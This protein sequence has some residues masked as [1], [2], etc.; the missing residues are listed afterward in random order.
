MRLFYLSLCLLLVSC[1]L[2]NEKL[3]ILKE[4]SEIEKFG[5]DYFINEVN[6][7]QFTDSLYYIVDSKINSLFVLDEDFNFITSVGSMGKGPG[8]FL[9][10]GTVSITSNK[11]YI[12]DVQQNSLM[13]YAKSNYML[14]EKIRLPENMYLSYGDFFID[15]NGNVTTAFITKDLTQIGIYNLNSQKFYPFNLKVEI[16]DARLYRYVGCLDNDFI[17]VIPRYS[18]KIHFFSRRNF[19]KLKEITIN[20]PQNSMNEWKKYSIEGK[21]VPLI[22]DGSFQANVLYLLYQDFANSSRA[23]ASIQLSSGLDVINSEFRIFPK[24]NGDDCINSNNNFLITFSPRKNT[25]QKY[26]NL[27]NTL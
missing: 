16:E 3:N 19:E 22:V 2:K 21:K 27:T 20:F 14:L 4:I 1:N 7:I 12:S 8:E 25:I 15:D 24:G 18:N 9:S 26:I 5:N 23:L 11:F 6:D 10:M 17:A 13:C